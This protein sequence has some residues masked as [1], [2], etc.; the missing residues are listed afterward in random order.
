MYVTLAPCNRCAQDI[1]Q[2]G[3]K[4]VIYYENKHGDRDT[5][6]A[7]RKMFRA[8]GVKQRKYRGNLKGLELIF[9]K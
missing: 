3:I 2:S 4:E 8:S 6:K 1:I 7:A 9:K 5:Y